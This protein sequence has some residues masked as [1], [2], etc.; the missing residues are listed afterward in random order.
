MKILSN[1][2]LAVTLLL[3]S[4]VVL[5]GHYVY[6]RVLYVEPVYDYH[7]DNYEPRY[8][9][10]TRVV[11]NE[12]Y[13]ERNRSGDAILGAIVGG[14][15]GRQ[16]GDGNGRDAATVSGALIGGSIA[17]NRGRDRYYGGRDCWEEP[18]YRYGN[19]GYR[20]NY[21]RYPNGYDVTYTINGRDRYTIR[22]NYDPGDRVRIRV[23]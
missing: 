15:V 3:V 12:R 8:G 10:R 17:H 16:F 1:I 2:I 5:A 20:S 6:G 21:N 18:D 11:C 13:I 14:A 7:Y 4:N 23:D 19:R 22:M 9:N